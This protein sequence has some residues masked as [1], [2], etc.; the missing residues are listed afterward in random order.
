MQCVHEDEGRIYQLKL[1]CD[2]DYPDK[3]PAVRFHSRINLACVHPDTGVV[4]AD[5]LREG[6]HDGAPPDAAQE[7]DGRAAQPQAAPAPRRHLL[8]F[9]SD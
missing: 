8:Q 9:L 2:K 4:E 5:K 3:P 1:V 7:G 6:V